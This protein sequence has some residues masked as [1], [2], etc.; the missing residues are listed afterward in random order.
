MYLSL[1][2][3]TNTDKIVYVHYKSAKNVY[4][5]HIPY[6]MCNW[7]R[8]VNESEQT[9]KAST[10]TQV[11][12]NTGQVCPS[13]ARDSKV[14]TSESDEETMKMG[15]VSRKEGIYMYLQLNLTLNINTIIN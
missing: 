15:K 1:A 4:I 11:L 10:G 2:H 9:L 5:A 7:S 6:S 14:Q 3:F 8:P 13:G 12:G